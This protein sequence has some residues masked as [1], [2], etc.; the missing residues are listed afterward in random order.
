MNKSF[1]ELFF[2][3]FTVQSDKSGFYA[4]YKMSVWLALFMK[5]LEV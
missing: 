2:N 1:A 4:G 5:I 3:V